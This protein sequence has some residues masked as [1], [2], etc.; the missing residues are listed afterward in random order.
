VFRGSALPKTPW[1]EF[2]RIQ[3]FISLAAQSGL[4]IPGDGPGYRDEPLD[5]V[6]ELG[7]GRWPPYRIFPALAIAQHHGIPTRL[8]DW[9][10]RPRIAAYFAAADTVLLDASKKEQGENIL[11]VWAFAAE[12]LG[13]EYDATPG[14]KCY[15]AV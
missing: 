10:Y 1:D 5:M 3:K 2:E 7:Q 6:K 15:G 4:D 9:T 8:L 11:A 13:A 12:L 14:D